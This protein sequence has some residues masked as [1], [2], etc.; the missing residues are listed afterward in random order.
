MRRTFNSS[1]KAIRKLIPFLDAFP[2]RWQKDRRFRS[3]WSD[4]NTHRKEIKAKLTEQSVKRQVKMLVE[5]GLD[6]GIEIIERSIFKGW[7]GLFDQAGGGK[8]IKQE[9]K[10]KKMGINIGYQFHHQG[11]LEDDEED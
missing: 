3:A 8:A 7:R 9:K 1:L 6:S 2:Y 5:Y 11:D 10:S 4:W